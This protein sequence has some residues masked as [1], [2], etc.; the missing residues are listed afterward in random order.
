[1]DPIHRLR[2]ELGHS[3]GAWGC[4]KHKLGCECRFCKCKGSRK[5]LI[6]ELMLRLDPS[7]D[8][9]EVARTVP[10][11]V[12]TAWKVAR[13]LGLIDTDRRVTGR[14]GPHERWHVRRGRHNPDCPL[15]RAEHPGEGAQG[16]A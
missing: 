11:S 15:C 9:R 7:L 10:C 6:A 3:D 16:A 12:T 8:Y 2:R 1:M 4:R 14:A 5:A 13:R